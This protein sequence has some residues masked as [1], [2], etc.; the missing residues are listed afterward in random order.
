MYYKQLLILL[1]MLAVLWGEQIAMA[2]GTAKI[3]GNVS[4]VGTNVPIPFANVTAITLEGA[5]RYGTQA[6]FEGDYTIDSLREGM[7]RIEV[8]FKNYKT[9]Y[10]ENVEVFDGETTYADIELESG[11]SK[12]PK[13]LKVMAKDSKRLRNKR[14][15]NEQKALKNLRPSLCSPY[16]SKA[17]TTKTGFIDTQI[18]RK[19]TFATDVDNTSYTNIEQYLSA[20]QFPPDNLV[21]VEEIINHFSYDYKSPI[22]GETFLADVEIAECP[23]NYR[24]KLAV[25]GLQ[26]KS[27]KVAPDTPTSN[28]VFLIDLSGSMNQEDKLPLLKTAFRNLTTQLSANDRVAIIAYKN[29]ATTLLATTAGNEQ[30]KILTA[31]DNLTAEGTTSSSLG[32]TLAYSMAQDNFT[33]LGNNTIVFASDGTLSMDKTTKANVL[34]MIAEKREKGIFLNVIGF[35]K[36]NNKNPKME[37]LAQHGNGGYYF[38]DNVDRAE[39]VLFSQT[40]SA[41]NVVAKDLDIMVKFNSDMVEKHRLIGYL[42]RAGRKKGKNCNKGRMYSGQNVT[43][44]Y[45]FIPTDKGRKTDASDN[46][47]TLNVNYTEP[48]TKKSALYTYNANTLNIPK[49][50]SAN[51]KTAATAAAYGLNVLYV[52]QRLDLDYNEILAYL[53]QGGAK[54][55]TPK[56]QNFMKMIE[57]TSLLDN[58]LLE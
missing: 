33:P 11:R 25:I 10:I 12:V 42:D 44:V 32:L 22:L 1:S 51:F 58:R 18:Y 30:Q 40:Q 34:D 28:I 26:A 50:T 8:I 36:G 29:E 13:N 39:K 55:N 49:S 24:S 17:Y 19:S 57:K 56:H 20:E 38:V 54:T 23:W 6:N 46:F 7:Y 43:V 4:A 47:F 21:H 3:S 5:L 52:K 9:T 41:G 15:K 53:R 37:A 27:I 35:G 45:E 16:Y 2:Q 14:L 31:I 48:N